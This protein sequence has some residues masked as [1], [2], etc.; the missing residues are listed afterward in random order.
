VP[1]L[2]ENG[3]DVDSCP[4]DQASVVHRGGRGALPTQVDPANHASSLGAAFRTRAGLP[5]WQDSRSML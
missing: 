3:V 1:D 2:A 5:G 4:W